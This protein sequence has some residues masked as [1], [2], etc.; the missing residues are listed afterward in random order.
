MHPPV[1]DTL[2]LATRLKNGG[3]DPRDAETIARAM[4]AEL[5]ERMAAKQDFATL[6]ARVEAAHTE[7][8]AEF[9]AVRGEMAAEFKAVRGE[10]AAEFKAV[11]AEMAGGF[12]AVDARI[13]ALD[14]RISTQGRFV[15]LILAILAG[16][17]IFNATTP[18]MLRS[19]LRQALS[20]PQVAV[21]QPAAKI[22]A[23][24]GVP[25]QSAIDQRQD[26]TVAAPTPTRLDHPSG[27]SP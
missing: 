14:N 11:R 24:A 15:F 4:G 21:A 8:G 19:E 9:K 13:E 22:S 25:S 17:G 1:I 2:G 23:A 18:Y 7:M 16:L 3:V 20:A 5:T 12:K 26:G 6:E 10:M 27:D